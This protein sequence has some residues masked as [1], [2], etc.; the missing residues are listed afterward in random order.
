MPGF[1]SC[2]TSVRNAVYPQEKSDLSPFGQAIKDKKYKKA[3]SLI[4]KGVAI[5]II[6]NNGVNNLRQAISK[7]SE[8]TNI[9]LIKAILSKVDTNIVNFVEEW[10]GP[11]IS[12]A[13]YSG[14]LE[15]MNLLVANGAD[16]NMG[17]KK[18]TPLMCAMVV[19][20]FNGTEKGKQIKK[21][22]DGQLEIVNALLRYGAKID[23]KNENGLTALEIH[24]EE[25]MGRPHGLINPRLISLLVAHGADPSKILKQPSRYIVPSLEVKALIENAVQEGLCQKQIRTNGLSSVI[26][27]RPPEYDEKNALL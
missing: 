4:Q 9:A 19:K 17:R 26:S 16:V 3:L 22:F 20:V 11:P 1:C 27:D 6:E 15:I 7:K 14:N 23:E 10:S 13:I 8:K 18:E 12:T 21:E 5:Q 25:Y 24:V 2:V